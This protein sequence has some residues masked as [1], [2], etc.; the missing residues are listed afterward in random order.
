MVK[1]ENKKVKGK[2]GYCDNSILG[3]KDKFGNPLKGGH[4]VY[5]R[6]TDNNG[7]C[8]VNII[9]SLEDKNGNFNIFK[10]GKVKRGYLY[11]IPKNDAGFSRWSAINLD[12]N[13]KGVDLSKIKDI[14]KVNMKRRHRFFVGKFTKK[15]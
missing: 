11:P 12:G 2:I 14:G 13:I 15:N 10:L 9:T 8:N 6:D 5:I 1:K 7:K 4:Y 3:I